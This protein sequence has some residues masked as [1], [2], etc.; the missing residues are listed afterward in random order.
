M[1]D[2]NKL[3]ERLKNPPK[4]M[5]KEPQDPISPL[6]FGIDCD[7]VLAKFKIL[8]FKMLTKITG[9]IYNEDSLLEWDFNKFLPKE[10]VNSLWEYINDSPTFVNAIEPFE[11]AQSALPKLLA[12]GEIFIVTAPLI[13]CDD[14]MRKRNSWLSKHF[15][16]EPANIC[17]LKRKEFF[18]CDVF[19]DDHPEN[20]IAWR[21]RNSGIAILWKKPYNNIPLESEFGKIIRTCDW[22][23]VLEVSK[24]FVHSKTRKGSKIP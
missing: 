4:F 7:E 10:E 8:A 1:E 15:K 19:I 2:L 18:G 24:K 6:V 14:F 12:L 5:I 11:E 23:E 17:Y 9:K 16:I 20:V 21:K 13:K 22:D 3:K